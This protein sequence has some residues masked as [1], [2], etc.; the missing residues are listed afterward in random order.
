MQSNPHSLIRRVTLRELDGT[1]VIEVDGELDLVSGYDLR[2][3]FKTVLT[4]STGAVTLDLSRV[5][6]VDD[7]GLSS[8]EWCSARVVEAHRPVEWT[9]CIHPVIRHLT[10]RLATSDSLAPV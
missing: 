5:T 9:G 6:A 1:C 7:Q 2:H 10:S 3:A 4:T 8:L